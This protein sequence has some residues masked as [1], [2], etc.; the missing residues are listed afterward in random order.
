M[1][2]VLLSLILSV[3]VSGL[4]WLL[5]GSRLRLDPDP[6]AN[7]LLNLGVYAA[8]AFAP[9]FAAVFLGLAR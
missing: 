4:A 8:L 9:L 2:A 5:L 7:D 1:I 6:K 3:F